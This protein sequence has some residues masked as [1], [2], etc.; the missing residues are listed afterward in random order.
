[1]AIVA[2]TVAICRGETATPAPKDT[3][4]RVMSL[5][6]V[7]VGI[8]PAASPGNPTPVGDP[9]PKSAKVRCSASLPVRSA[10]IEIPTLLEWAMMSPSV[11]RSVACSSASWIVYPS[12]SRVAGTV[13]RSIGDTAPD[14]SAAPAVIVLLTDPG[15][16]VSV[17]ARLTRTPGF[18]SAKAFGS[19]LGLFAIA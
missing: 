5:Q 14:S 17:T 12:M 16:H 11:M 3:V 9:N 10:T 19:K 4:A 7:E 8:K 2:Y 15:S 1:M 13:N 18:A 6:S